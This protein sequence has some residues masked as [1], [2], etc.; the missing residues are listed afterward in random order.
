MKK[1]KKESLKKR[2][3]MGAWKWDSKDQRGYRESH[4]GRKVMERK[5][6]GDVG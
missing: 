5:D 6:V 2:E 3:N 1:K 4:E